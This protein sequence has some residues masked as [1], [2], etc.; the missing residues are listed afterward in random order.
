MRRICNPT[1]SDI[2]TCYPGYRVKAR[3][4]D[5]TPRGGDAKRQE[6]LS[7]T[8]A[9]SETRQSTTVTPKGTHP[10]ASQAV[11]SRH[12][13]EMRNPE[14]NQSATLRRTCNPGYRVKARY[15]DLTPRGGD[16]KR[17][18]CPLRRTCNPTRQRQNPSGTNDSLVGDK[19][20]PRRGQTTASSGTNDNNPLRRTCNPTQSYK[21]SPTR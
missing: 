5:L 21:D 7:R 9:R 15:D 19:R 17:Q 6:C 12:S 11:G 10:T 14:N 20:Q 2:R 4:D 16:A 13:A 8:T 18:E 1:Q 3:Y